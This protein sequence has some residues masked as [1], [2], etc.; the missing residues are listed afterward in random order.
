MRYLLDTSILV[1]LYDSTSN[2]RIAVK[3]YLEKLDAIGD[4]LTVA[5]QVIYE[6]WVVAT[7]P[8]SVNGLGMSPDEADHQIARLLSLFE[9]VLES[10]MVFKEWRKQVTLNQ[11]SGKLSH[12]ARIVAFMIVNEIENLLTLNPNDFKRFGEIN[13]V[14]LINI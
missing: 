9:L 6:F 13:V 10:E 2:A 7:R 5:P 3:Q 4:E 1:R 8:R 14:D 11:V 12:D